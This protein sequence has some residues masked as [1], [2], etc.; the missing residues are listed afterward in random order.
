LVKSISTE[1]VRQAL[2]KTTSNPGLFNQ[3]ASP[4]KPTRSSF[5]GWRMSFR[6][7]RS[8]LML[9]HLFVLNE[10]QKRPVNAYKQ[11]INIIEP[12]YFKVWIN[13]VSQ[14]CLRR[15]PRQVIS[16][17]ANLYEHRR[18]HSIPR[19]PAGAMRGRR[20]FCNAKRRSCYRRRRLEHEQTRENRLGGPFGGRG[21]GVHDVLPSG[22]HSRPLSGEVS[23]PE[24]RSI[25]SPVKPV[26]R[27]S[28]RNRLRRLEA[29]GSRCR[30]RSVGNDGQKSVPRSPNT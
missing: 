15:N 29:D 26:C 14:F 19:H 23:G 9:S 22:K 25:S 7:T 11:I 12:S 4:R 8:A 16:S 30:V 28:H 6:R 3:G 20:H 18:T 2:K 1:T 5:G 21:A 27:E 13:F 24:R 10:C 17:H